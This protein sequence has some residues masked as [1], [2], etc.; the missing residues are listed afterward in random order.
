MKPQA[1]AIGMLIASLV[2]ASAFAADVQIAKPTTRID[3]NK[4]IDSN[5]A[6]KSNLQKTVAG[7]ET[8]SDSEVATDQRKTMDFIDIEM[9]QKDENRPVVDRRFNSEGEPRVAPEF[10]S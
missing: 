4:M 1:S 3:F 6:E 2:S 8:Q 9:M 5:N 7:E 10:G